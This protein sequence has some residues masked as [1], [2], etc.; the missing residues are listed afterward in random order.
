MEIKKYIKER[1]FVFF[2]LLLPYSSSMGVQ[3]VYL[4]HGLWGFPFEFYKIRNSLNTS[5]IK[6]EIYSYYSVNKPIKE[7]AN[8]LMKK[9]KDDRSDTISIVTHSMGALVV[10]S[11]LQQAD[12]ISNF[13]NIYR[14]VMIAPPNQGANSAN[15]LYKKKCFRFLFG[16]NLKEI[17][18]FPSSLSKTL[19]VPKNSEVGIIAGIFKDDNDGEI[20]VEETK[21]GIEK[22]FI[23]VKSHHILILQK[24]IT[25]I[26]VVN[27]L[28]KGK[29]LTSLP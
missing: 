3:K 15:K 27:F 23:T 12:S 22:D 8:T 4:I 17:C 29:F 16:V 18:N 25:S 24:K 7:S 6:T 21:L 28:K 2:L 19:P 11:M 9:I 10:R 1:I 14:I 13:P 20:K 5:G 26:Y